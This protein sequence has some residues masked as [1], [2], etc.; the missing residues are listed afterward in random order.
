MDQ[1]H[2]SSTNKKI[3]AISNRYEE[4][5]TNNDTPSIKKAALT[6]IPT[7][8]CLTT[9][10]NTTASPASGVDVPKKV[11]ED[12]PANTSAIFEDA[13]TPELL[14]TLVSLS[15][16]AALCSCLP[17]PPFSSSTSPPASSSLFSSSTSPLASSSLFS[18]SA[19]PLASSSL[20]SSSASPP[21]S[22]SLFSSSASPLASSSLFSS[23][24]SPPASSSLFSSSTSPP[25]SYTHLTLPTR[26]TV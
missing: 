12:P 7:S 26:R 17:F 13:L 16:S 20:F 18:S 14:T 24:T 25:V 23:S 8:T 22:S 9:R 5:F 15:S 10:E 21:A 11:K 1:E 4:M 6:V 19:S 2:Q 3:L